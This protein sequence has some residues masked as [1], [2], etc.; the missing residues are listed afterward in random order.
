[1]SSEKLSEEEKIYTENM[2]VEDEIS[3]QQELQT[4]QQSHETQEFDMLS[5]G[6]G[7]NIFEFTSNPNGDYLDNESNCSI[8]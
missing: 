3:A 1:M 2:I 8:E 5:F 4:Q 6:Y 7:N